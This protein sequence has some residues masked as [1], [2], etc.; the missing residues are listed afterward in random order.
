MSCSTLKKFNER[1]IL[2]CK[3]RKEEQDDFDAFHRQK[4]G[5]APV[6]WGGDIDVSDGIDIDNPHLNVGDIIQYH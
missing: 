6:N 3:I 1:E 2:V 5:D 4:R